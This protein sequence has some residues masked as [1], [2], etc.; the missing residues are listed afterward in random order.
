MAEKSYKQKIGISSDGSRGSILNRIG[1]SASTLMRATIVQP[2][3]KHIGESL[4]AVSSASS[5]SGP[6]SG[7]AQRLTVSQQATFESDNFV[8][9][10]RISSLLT[11][12]FRTSTYGLSTSTTSLQ[13]EF[14]TFSAIPATKP[15]RMPRSHK[16]CTTFQ[17]RHGKQRTS[18]H[19]DGAEVVDLLSDPSFLVNEMADSAVD[20]EPLDPYPETWTPNDVDRT[21]LYEPRNGLTAPPVHHTPSPT[22]PLNLIPDFASGYHSA[23]KDLMITVPVNPMIVEIGLSSRSSA[24][25]SSTNLESWL[26]VLTRYQDDV[27]GDILPLVKEARAE[28]EISSADGGAALVDRPAT[29]RL[30]MILGHF[31]DFSNAAHLQSPTCGHRASGPFTPTHRCHFK[32]NSWE[33]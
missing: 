21:I 18:W 12:S 3:P 4:V 22:N 29:R 13:H 5:K 28:M 33:A 2:Q 27:W 14:N 15:A 24:D 26:D 30:A 1:S 17:S 16:T 10:D 23:N 9:G 31:D 11:E 6:S 8:S 19:G 7:L 25:P 20:V 32:S